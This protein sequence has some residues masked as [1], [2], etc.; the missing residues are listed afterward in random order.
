MTDAVLGPGPKGRRSLSP[1]ETLGESDEEADS[2]AEGGEDDGDLSN[3]AIKPIKLDFGVVGGG[4]ET[5]ERKAGKREES[6]VDEWSR[7]NLGSRVKH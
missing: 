2:D 1:Y 4:K 6:L 3:S 7:P 5:K